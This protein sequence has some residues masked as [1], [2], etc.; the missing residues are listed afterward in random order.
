MCAA[1]SHMPVIRPLNISIPHGGSGG[2]GGQ[3]GGAGGGSAATPTSQAANTPG[4]FGGGGDR[5][6]FHHSPPNSPSGT[7][8]PVHFARKRASEVMAMVDRY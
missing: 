2:S 3:A 7:S 6:N 4:R 5:Q 1:T 8:W